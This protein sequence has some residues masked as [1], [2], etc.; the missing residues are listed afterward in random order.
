MGAYWAVVTFWKSD[1]FARSAVAVVVGL[2]IIPAVV[3][4]IFVLFANRPQRLII[5][6][7]RSLPGLLD[8]LHSNKPYADRT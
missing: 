4:F 8:D 7:L 1:T 5:P 6:A 2:A 3:L